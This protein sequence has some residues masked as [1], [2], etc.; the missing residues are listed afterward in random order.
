MVNSM[1]AFASA[2]GAQDGANWAWEIRSVNG[3]GLDV[4]MR[5]PEGCESLE[6]LL[7]AE[8]GKHCKRGNIN[9][10]L[11]MKRDA[12]AGLPKLNIE[13]LEAAVWAAKQALASAKAEGLEVAPLQ[14]SGLLGL[15]NVFE[16]RADG[17]LI[18]Q[19]I[20][21]L[22]KQDISGLVSAFSEAR[23][24]EGKALYEILSRQVDQIEKHVSDSA[25]ILDAR[26]EKVSETLRVNVAKLLL[27]T[28]RQDEARITQELA[29]LAV[30]SDVTEEID[31]LQAHIEAARELLAQDGP[32]GRKFDFLTQEFNREANTLC[33]K[34]N[35]TDLTRI[36]LD[37]KTVIDQM[38]EQVQNVE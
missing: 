30:K 15:S 8:I 22:V 16:V 33:S 19:E 18:N 38:R 28:E 12:A 3:R 13:A 36:G 34:S 17:E 24:S 27:N 29:L 10:T 6:A 11:K 9:V 21:D 2:G 7:K 20:L 4:R 37:L 1:T 35:F 31:R 25:G 26:Q 14:V 23:A 5:L 32:I